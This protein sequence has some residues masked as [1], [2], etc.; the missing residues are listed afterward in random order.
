M[1]RRNKRGFK[2]D[3]TGRSI[4][5]G[6][7]YIILSHYMLKSPA[8]KTLSP[9]AKALLLDVWTRHNG[10]NNG[11]IGYSVR[12]AEEIGLSKSPT[13][14]AFKELMERGF[15]KMHRGSAFT[16]RTKEARTW[17]LTG[18]RCQDNPATKDY[19]TW[20]HQSPQRDLGAAGK[21]KTQSPQRD[22][23][24]PQRDTSARK[25]PETAVLVP[26]EGPIDAETA[27]FR[28]PQRDT[29]NIPS[30]L[31]DGGCSPEDDPADCLLAEAALPVLAGRPSSPPDRDPNVIDLEELIAAASTAPSPI[32]QL[33]V[34][35]KVK[36]RDAP[37][38]EQ[39]RVAE[40]VHLSRPQISN[41][42]AGRF[43]V[44]KGALHLLR[45]YAEGKLAPA[46][47]G[48]AANAQ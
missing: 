17:E 11:E 47:D 37:K 29:Y 7:R 44:N 34:M 39:S 10:M 28:S 35:L 8:W 43:N 31:G 33:R 48:G 45:E 6:E 22:A 1:E 21:N 46:L 20:G 18:E 23:W 2:A 24:S 12:E 36:L 19:M 42:I 5:G 15:L 26:P 41:F 25:G 13:A 14:R 40:L 38:G 4:G 32:D 3:A 30:P 27:P 16:L 9:N